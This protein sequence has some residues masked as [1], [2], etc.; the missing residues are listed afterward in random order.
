MKPQGGD[1]EKESIPYV[2]V[3]RFP[4]VTEVIS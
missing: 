3:C 1:T 4:P 2:C